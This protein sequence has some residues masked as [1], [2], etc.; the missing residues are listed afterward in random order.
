MRLLLV[1]HA[2]AE[3][4]AEGHSDAERALTRAG[5]ARFR[6]GSL[7]WLAERGPFDRLLHSPWRRAAQTAAMMKECLEDGA[8]PESLAAL[9]QPPD[10]AALAQCGGA[11][12]CAVGHQP[13]LTELAALAC[14]GAPAVEFA[15]RIALRKG[16][17]IL[18]EGE[19]TPGAMRL[20]ELFAPPRR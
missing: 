6:R 1:R 19:L 20:L 9:A 16:G 10:A 5:R 12:V 4:R 13:W 7:P 11:R 3:P 18:L 8:A 14:C 17:A 15:A 2:V